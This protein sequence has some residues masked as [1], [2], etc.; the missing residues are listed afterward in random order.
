MSRLARW[1]DGVAVLAAALMAAACGGGED[2]SPGSGA[3]GAGAAV[4]GGSAT[5]GGSAV[6]TAGSSSGGAASSVSSTCDADQVKLAFDGQAEQLYTTKTWPSLYGA[7]MG[8]ARRMHGLLGSGQYDLVFEPEV[9]GTTSKLPQVISDARPW[10]VR[11]GLLA[12]ATDQTLGP[13]RCVT[14]GSGSTLARRDDELLLD[15]K[16][17]D[18]MATCGDRGVEGQINL[19]FNFSGCD[20]FDGGSVGGTP[21]VLQPDT[22]IG[23]GGVWAVDFNEGSYMVAR[24]TGAVSGP[25]YWALIV[26]S[27]NGP[28]A[29]EVYCASGGSVEKTEGTLGYTV[30]HLTGLGAL[31][32][33]S[34][35]GTAQ[36]CLQGH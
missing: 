23:G 34:G 17:M 12:E 19:C 36:G 15:L 6:S 1:M 24:A 16:N 14:P 9:D 7:D 10:P 2:A 29:G 22:W 35:A 13:V 27:P 18:V 21:W 31:K 3:A 26:T 30:I 32:C 33:G 4:A 20:N 25:A 5:S 28:Y 8:Q 11:R